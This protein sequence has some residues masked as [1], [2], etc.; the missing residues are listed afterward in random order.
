MR[1]TRMLIIA[2]IVALVAAACG[3]GD[4]TSTSLAAT[5][6]SDSVTPTT[7]PLSSVPS[8]YVGYLHQP[9]ACGA[10]RPDPAIDMKFDAPGEAGQQRIPD[11]FG[12]L[13]R[14]VGI[15]PENLVSAFLD[16]RLVEE[17]L[18]LFLERAFRRQ[19]LCHQAPP[20]SASTFGWC[21]PPAQKVS[22]FPLANLLTLCSR[23]TLIRPGAEWRAIRTARV[24]NVLAAPPSARIFLRSVKQS[25]CR[26]PSPAAEHCRPVQGNT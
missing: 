5:G 9:T 22:I 15:R 17:S 3:G 14:D 11:C 13:V 7:V 16:A 24:G 1:A 21:T 19:Q 8:D 20:P 2:A 26:W 25:P 23:D 10:E 4:S 12:D 6:A 18:H